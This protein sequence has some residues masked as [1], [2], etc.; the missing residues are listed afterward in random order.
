MSSS[1]QNESPRRFDLTMPV[2]YLTCML[3]AL[4][5]YMVFFYAPTDQTMG[6]VQR[7]LY[8][9]VSLAVVA[10]L[11]SFLVMMSSVVFLVTSRSIWDIRASVAAKIG[12]LFCTLGLVTGSLWIKPAW[13]VWWIWN[14]HLTTML[15]IWIMLIVYLL[16]RKFVTAE[17]RTKLAGVV[18][19]MA[20]FTLPSIV[21]SLMWWRT[22]HPAS[23]SM[24]DSI[25]E[26]ESRMAATLA[27]SVL[28][29]IMMF[30]YFLQHRVAMEHME[31]DLEA[32]REALAE[33]QRAQDVLV[34]NQNFI[35]EGYT[36]KEYKKHD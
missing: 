15:T 36:F 33:E 24:E 9:H 29:S 23:V 7:I 21:V 30:L 5:L 12:A 26:L 17:W 4:M 25:L 18:G 35:I 11:A 1:L 20:F 31:N 34:E 2:C 6:I 22:L 28:T 10:L 13:N 3:I 16:L 19:V 27:V 14:V 8:V 32:I